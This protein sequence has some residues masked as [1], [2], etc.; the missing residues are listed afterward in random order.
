MAFSL[1]EGPPKN[2]ARQNGLNG[3]FPFFCIKNTDK[4]GLNSSSMG[5][6]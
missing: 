5:I 3:Q 6:E 2:H 4:P 1:T